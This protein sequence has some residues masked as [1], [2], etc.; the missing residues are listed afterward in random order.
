MKILFELAPAWDGELALLREQLK[1]EGIPCQR[2]PQDET[3]AEKAV[4]QER[5]LVLT[6]R[7]ETGRKLA[8]QGI[9]YVG[10]VKEA[11]FEGAALVLESLEG[12]DGRYLEEWMQRLQ[13][14]PARI[15]CTKRLVI[16]EIA[17]GDM[18]ALIRIFGQQEEADR[19]GT[20]IFTEEGLLAYM[21]TAY[22]LQGYGLWSVLHQGEIIGCCG[23]A[24][25]EPAADRTADGI[26][27]SQVSGS[28]SFEGAGG[29]SILELQYMVGAAYRRQGFGTEMCQ[30]A[31]AYARERLN[32]KEVW[33][34]IRRG[35]TASLALAKKLGFFRP[36]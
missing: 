4:H 19:A 1:Q 21:R 30:A 27:N 22:R 29:S 10:C 7:A 9:P 8:R 25:F 11:W 28:L 26:G 34:R 33:V 20:E 13:G 17:E 6:D 35:N 36:D 23:F 2:M 31:L 15:A 14:L 32:V 3:A 5:T 12:I 16:R 24:P 18:E